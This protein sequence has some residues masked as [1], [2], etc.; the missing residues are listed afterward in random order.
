MWLD[1]RILELEKWLHLGLTCLQGVVQLNQ[2]LAGFFCTCFSQPA[3]L[4]RLTGVHPC[5]TLQG[6]VGTCYN[7]INQLIE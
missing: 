5:L 3:S 1:L 4:A 6:T 7:K 2:E